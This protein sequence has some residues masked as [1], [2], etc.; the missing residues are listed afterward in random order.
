[1]KLLSIASGSS[2]NCIYVGNEDTHILIDAGISGKKVE[3]GLKSIG[4]SA[5]DLDGVFITHEHIDHIGGLGVL[6]RKCGLPIYATKGTIQGILATKSVGNIEM[7][8][9]HPFEGY[10]CCQVGSLTIDPLPISHDA[11]DPVAY[12]IYCGEKR[13]G[14]VTDLG[15]VTEEV[16]DGFQDMD[17]LFIEANHD[18]RML[19]AG[20]YPY[21]LKKRIAGK[22]GHL[23]NESSGRLLSNIV[24]DH[25]KY[26]MLGHLSHENNLPELAYEA[27]R[28]EINMGDN[29]YRAEDFYIS[30]AKRSEPSP[31]IEF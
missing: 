11:R 19:Q 31:L 10:G 27:V 25:L 29:P 13:L 14:I 22:K 1:M 2:G 30:V 21:Y 3:A 8:L 6:A 24:N 23:S 9:F 18:E 12:R 17:A 26:I 16:V 28:L 5:A 4:L 20:A 15:I 7:E